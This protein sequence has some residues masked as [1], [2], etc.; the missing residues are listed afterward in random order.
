MRNF[1]TFRFEE[2]ADPQHSYPIGDGDHG[3]ISTK[4][5]QNFGI[6]YIRVG[7]MVDGKISLEK[8]VYIPEEVHSKNIHQE[9]VPGDIIIAKTGATIGKVAIIPKS[10]PR[11]NTT[12]SVGKISIDYS[13]VDVRYFFHYLQTHAFTSQMWRV[14]HK[15]AQPGFNVKHL[16]NFTIPLPPLNEQK[17]IATILDKAEEIK[18]T[19]IQIQDSRMRIIQS[20]FVE[21]F[22]DPI[23]NPNNYSKILFGELGTLDR[24]K[25]KHRPR[26]DPRLL[27]GN[28][29]L[30][31]TGEIRSADL[32]VDTF[33]STYSDFG[34][35]QSRKWPAGTL[36]ITIAANIAESAILG[37]E[38]CFPDSIVGFTPNSNTNSIFIKAQLDFLKDRISEVAPQS[39]QKN[40]NLK[41]LRE[42]PMMCPPVEMQEQFE[43]FVRNAT[44]VF[45]Y[46]NK[47]LNVAEELTQSSVQSLF[48]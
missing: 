5:Y 47:R 3:A 6:P 34:L 37:I 29:P 12:A 10:I 22:G 1:Q 36:A 43:G 45:D 19:S 27:G 46:A 15:S 26:N 44:Q 33:I 20:A 31:Q 28:H 35:A 14:S 9:L 7:D 18:K 2:I 41:I 17:R 42:I 25:S 4:C 16:K 13:K 23:L 8:M 38:A 32:F 39:A 40:I 48:N 30:I 24:G 11:A 21:M